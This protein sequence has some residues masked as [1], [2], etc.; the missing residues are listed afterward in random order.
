MT[1]ARE[2]MP[3]LGARVLVRFESLRIECT[4]KDVKNS[5]GQARLLVVPVAG[6][7]EQWVEMGRIRAEAAP[8]LGQL[9]RQ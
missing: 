5:W 8:G 1:T 3:A 9:A 7:G 2:M 6:T 4:V